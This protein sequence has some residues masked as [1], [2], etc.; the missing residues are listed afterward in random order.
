MNFKKWAS[1]RPAAFTQRLMMNNDLIAYFER[2]E[3]MAFFSGYPFIYALVY[4]ISDKI[5]KSSPV[6]S[7]KLIVLLPFAYALTATLFVASS[8]RDI[9]PNYTIES[10]TGQFFSSYLRIWGLMAVVFWLPQIGRKHILSLLHSLIFFF[11]LLKD[12]LMNATSSVDNDVI[13]NDMAIYT[14]SLLINT[15][16]FI[17]LMLIHFISH[18]IGNKKSS[19]I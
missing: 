5:R 13:R 1:Q 9:Y 4:F 15:G 11:L 6:L 19:V 8:L 16:S 18:G 2:L 14:D 3:L 17:I 7:G 10:I 12:L